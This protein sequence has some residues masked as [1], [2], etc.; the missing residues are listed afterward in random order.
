MHIH[1]PL[2]PIRALLPLGLS[3]VFPSAWNT[4]V[5]TSSY[6]DL[7]VSASVLLTPGSL[8]HPLAQGKV[9]WPQYPAVAFAKITG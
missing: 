5:L 7:Q 6:H 9:F 1:L 3:S 8:P 2:T 4:P